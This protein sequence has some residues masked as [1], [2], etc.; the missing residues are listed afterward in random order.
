MFVSVYGE[1]H[2]QRAQKLK[3]PQV[4]SC[5][6]RGRRLNS[7]DG[8]RDQISHALQGKTH[9]KH[10]AN[11]AM[12]YCLISETSSEGFLQEMGTNVETHNWTAHR[13]WETSERSPWLGCFYP[14]P[15]LRAQGSVRK[16]EQR[17]CES[18]RW[19]GRRNGKIVRVKSSEEDGTEGLGEPEVVDYPRETVFSRHNGAGTRGKL[20]RLTC[21]VSSQTK[22]R[23]RGEV[24]TE[25]LPAKELFA[26]LSWRERENQL[27]SVNW[28][29]EYP[30][31]CTAAHAQ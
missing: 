1:E 24:G 26:S 22:S 23:H 18:Q 5:M 16:R 27:S 14:T 30:L 28:H 10:S 21:T 19:W 31:H 7:G 3:H 9:Y 17:D 13:E 15:V 20:Q 6:R 8:T 25:S 12:T 2:R 4:Q 11:W 29:W